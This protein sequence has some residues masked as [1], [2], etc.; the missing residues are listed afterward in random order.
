MTFEYKREP[1]EEYEIEQMRK[2]CKS[3]EEELVV[4][5]LLET[6]L[7]VSE[8][9]RLREENCSWQR[10]CITLIGKGNRRRVIPMS[11]TTRFYL[12]A[13]F[14]NEPKIPL[15]SRTIQKYVQDVAERARIKKK[16][17]P[18]V[19]RHTFAVCYLHRGGNLRALQ[20]ILG[21]SSITTTD[22]YLNYSGERVIQDF[23]KIWEP[24]E[25]KNTISPQERVPESNTNKPQQIIQEMPKQDNTLLNYIENG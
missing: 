23:Q 19:L 9:S 25:T 3:F 22:I 12:S 11:N 8:L 13:I 6:G 5:V 17:S 14:K 4:N 7:R 2:N 15:A 24:K 21:H 16:V 18:H 20:G 10:S 1:L